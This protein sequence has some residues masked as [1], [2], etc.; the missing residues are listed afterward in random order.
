MYWTF[1]KQ[2]QTD[3]NNDGLLI[4]GIFFIYKIIFLRFAVSLT[5]NLFLNDKNSPQYVFLDFTKKGEV[6]Y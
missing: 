2:R 3:Y 1:V 6:L 4:N 5:V